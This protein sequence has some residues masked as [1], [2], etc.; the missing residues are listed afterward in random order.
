MEPITVQVRCSGA[1]H[2]IRLDE[3]GCL[4]FAG[5]PNGAWRSWR[6]HEA[7]S[8]HPCRCEE[9]SAAWRD[10]APERLPTAFAKHVRVQHKLHETRLAYRTAAP[11]KLD[12]HTRLHEYVRRAAATIFEDCDY[13]KASSKWAGG[14]H[15]IQILILEDPRIQPS[16]SGESER[17]WSSNGKWSGNNSRLKAAI[18][19]DWLSRVKNQGSART[20]E[21]FILDA[22]PIE[23]PRCADKA[24]K[25]LYAAQGRGFDLKREEGFVLRSGSIKVL[26]KSLRAAER[27][28]KL[29]VTTHSSA[30]RSAP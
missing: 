7:L 6:V 28:L 25:V 19:I 4:H 3:R 9:I 20:A 29:A 17:E 10:G 18:R 14:V 1:T 2:T 24:W 30:V 26:A 11:V 8:G 27:A 12:F 22:E 13:R 5:H 16:C 15:S 21:R 23:P